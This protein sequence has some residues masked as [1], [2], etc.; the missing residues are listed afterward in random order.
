MSALVPGF[1]FAACWRDRGLGG[2][3]RDRRRAEL[4]GT[5]AVGD[6]RQH[7]GADGRETPVPVLC[8]G[9]VPAVRQPTRYPVRASAE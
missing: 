8:Y 9:R 2:Q 1:G 7:L 3:L 4:D 5:V 6:P